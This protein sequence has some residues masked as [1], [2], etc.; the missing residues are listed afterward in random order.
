MLKRLEGGNMVLV[1]LTEAHHQAAC[2]AL[3]YQWKLGARE[4][5]GV[6]GWLGYGL[7]VGAGAKNLNLNLCRIGNLGNSTNKSAEKFNP[8]SSGLYLV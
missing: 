1:N 8:N 6:G 7:G 3:P 5:V 4:P 2:V